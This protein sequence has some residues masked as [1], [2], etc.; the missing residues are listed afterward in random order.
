VILDVRRAAEARG[1]VAVTAVTPQAVSAMEELSSSQSMSANQS[2]RGIG[3]ILQD[4]KTVE[5]YN[6]QEKD[7]LVCL[8]AKVRKERSSSAWENS[9]GVVPNRPCPSY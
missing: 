2:L 9:E 7:F 8:P 5:S 4:D 1:A 3:K 6:I